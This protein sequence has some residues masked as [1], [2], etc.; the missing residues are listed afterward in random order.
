MLHLQQGSDFDENTLFD[1]ETSN[2]LLVSSRKLL[3]AS[4]TTLELE[5]V[6]R[7]VRLATLT[8]L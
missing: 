8:F 7:R 3:K 5:K 2:L 1:R 6:S 4:F